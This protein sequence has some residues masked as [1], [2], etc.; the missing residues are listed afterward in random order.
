MPVGCN[1]HVNDLFVLILDGDSHKDQR[2][3][4]H[5]G[6]EQQKEEI[7][8]PLVEVLGQPRGAGQRL[9]E[10]LDDPGED[11]R[12]VGSERRAEQPERHGARTHHIRRLV[13][14]KLDLCD[15]R[16]DL[17]QSDQHVLRRL[18]EDRQAGGARLAAAITAAVVAAV[19]AVAVAARGAELLA[20]DLQTPPL[21]ARRVGHGQ[22]GNHHAPAAPPQHRHLVAQRPEAGLQHHVVH[23]DERDDGDGVKNSHGCGRDL[24]ALAIPFKAAVHVVALCDEHGAHLRVDGPVEDAAEE[25]GQQPQDKLHLLHLLGR[26][27]RPASNASV[28][29]LPVRLPL[30]DGVLQPAVARRCTVSLKCV[31]AAVLEFS[32]AIVTTAFGFC[33]VRQWWW[34]RW[35]HVALLHLVAER[36]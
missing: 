2:I 27:P 33:I 8:S 11:A 16:E 12:H 26:V 7:Q 30:G 10:C 6:H 18:P 14:E 3:A 28:A 36:S 31:V 19:V 9:A 24:E 17:R 13:I 15:G 5:Q 32:V 35:R 20:V 29:R 21:H 22:R 1:L 4:D 25:D 34:W 23:P